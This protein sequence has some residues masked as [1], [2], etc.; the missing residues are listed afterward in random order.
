LTKA[1]SIAIYLV[2]NTNKSV[3]VGILLHE[4]EDRELRRRSSVER[5]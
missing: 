4:C 3:G 5:K 1:Y 2:A